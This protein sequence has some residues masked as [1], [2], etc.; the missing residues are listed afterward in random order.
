[1][2]RLLRLIE[3]VFIFIMIPLSYYLKLINIH[4]II[5][6]AL[7][8]VFALMILLMDKSFNRRRLWNIKALPAS[9]KRIFLIFLI[10]AV[11][12][13]AGVIYFDSETLFGFVKRSPVTWA[14]VMVFYPALSAYPQ[15]LIYRAFFFHR[16]Q[17]LFPGR[18]QLIIASALSFGFMHITFKN[19]I[20]IIFTLVGGILF[21]CTYEKTKSLAS[22]TFEHA[23][24]GCYI[25]TIGLGQYFYH[26]AV[27]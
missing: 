3:F 7:V 23:L 12:I 6:L 1:M 18:W 19:P 11:I 16:Y 26:G 2:Q 9:F 25:F 8:T 4:M 15:E 24:Y 13:A 5:L 14:F 20:A 10:N 22:S 21:A 27:Q 17:I